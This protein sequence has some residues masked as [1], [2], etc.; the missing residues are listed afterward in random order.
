MRKLLPALLIAPLLAFIAACGPVSD[1]A[2][3]AGDEKPAASQAAEKKDEKKEEPKKEHKA[4]DD[5]TVKE[6]CKVGEF[7]LVE[8][9][10]TVK[11]SGDESRSYLI[12]IS[13]NDP[14]TGDRVAELNGAA[15]N[16]KAGQSAK[17]KTVGSADGLDKGD[18]LKCEIA[19]V[20]VI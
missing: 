6:D 20:T 4:E 3:N 17:V 15:N 5:V 13:A 1:D 10:V 9:D 8:A 14:K 2:T 16:I 7:G 12:T 19:N 11:N 18:K